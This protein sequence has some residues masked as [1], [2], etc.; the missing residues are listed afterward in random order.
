MTNFKRDDYGAII[1]RQMP[2]AILRE[3]CELVRKAAAAPKTEGEGWDFGAEFDKNGRGSALNWD[4]YGV[5]HDRHDGVLLIVVQVRQ[6]VRRRKNHFARI[7]KSYALVG[8]NED[9]TVFA[10]PVSAHKVRAAVNAGRCPVKAAQDWIFVCDYDYVFR[11]GDIALAPLV[12]VRQLPKV[13]P[14]GESEI[15][16]QGS[17]RLQGDEFRQ[18]GGLFVKNPR[19]V[20]EPGTHP[21]LELKAGWFRVIVG[22]RS[23]FWNFAPP[24]ID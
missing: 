6:F 10:H 8:T 16:I 1:Q 19:L 11:Q 2:C 12:N 7:R 9:G 17:H 21:L 15:I 20:H 22:Q 3:V 18:A 24:T 14:T 13:E 4:L 5:A 23:K